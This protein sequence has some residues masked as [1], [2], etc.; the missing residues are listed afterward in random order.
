[1]IAV[2]T[3]I[4]V[5]LLVRDDQTQYEKSR[6]V[7]SAEQIFIPD[8]VILETEWVLRY[9]YRFRPTEICTAFRKLLG[10]ENVKVSDPTALAEMIRWHEDGLDFADAFH[11]MLSQ[12]QDVLK[13]FDEK[14][15]KK[16]KGRSK[17]CVELP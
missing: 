6:A 12:E 14:F 15:I 7:F 9:A 3:N 11:L 1:M 4:L 16:A 10:L 13:S 17:C 8:S 2:D 5:R